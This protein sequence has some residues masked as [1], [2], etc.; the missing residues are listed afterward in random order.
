MAKKANN[1]S[2]KL[3]TDLSCKTLLVA[4]HH[5]LEELRNPWKNIHIVQTD[6]RDPASMVVGDQVRFKCLCKFRL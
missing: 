4:A 6:K 2:R 1:I 3:L 5:S